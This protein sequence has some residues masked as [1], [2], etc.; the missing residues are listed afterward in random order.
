MKNMSQ[1]ILYFFAVQGGLLA[2]NSSSRFLLLQESIS[3]IE[4]TRVYF[5]AS[6]A[7][8]AYKRAVD[9]I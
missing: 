8:E 1:G 5:Y 9:R 7:S 2:Q 4:P 6:S 3:Y